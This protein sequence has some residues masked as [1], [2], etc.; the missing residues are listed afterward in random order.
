MSDSST[1]RPSLILRLRYPDDA[2]A[3]QEFL[4]IY[5]PLVFRIAKSKGLQTADALDM[6]Q[7]V[8]V[9]VARAVNE[10][11]PDPDCGT[12]RG[13]IS[14]IAR[15]LVIDYLR[16]KN[17]RPQTGNDS[18]IR[19]L[20]EQVPADCAESQFYDL[21]H[22]R[23]VFLW[24]SER[25]QSQFQT[26]TWQAFWRTSVQQHSVE[27]V[28]AELFLTPGAVYIARSRVMARLKQ[29]VLQFA[30]SESHDPT[31]ASRHSGSIN[32]NKP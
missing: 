18:A 17:K 14:Q 7:E 8:L 27:R 3:W 28:A 6:T 4:E 12:F 19:Q 30:S 10:W 13:W 20:I 15:N 32:G 23:Q 1:T 29:T 24:A 21:E 2:T 5:Q 31:F 11:D 22:E 9:R 26:S 25:V 16:A